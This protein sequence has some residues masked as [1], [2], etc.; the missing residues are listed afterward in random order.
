MVIS[1]WRPMKVTGCTPPGV[2]QRPRSRWWP[3]PRVRGGRD[4]EVSP[5]ESGRR[6]RHPDLASGERLQL[7]QDGHGPAGGVLLDDRSTTDARQRDAV[8]VDGERHRD[9]R[10]QIAVPMLGR[11]LLDEGERGRSRAAGSV[12]GR[13]VSEDC[14][15]AVLADLAHVSAKRLGLLDHPAQHAGRQRRRRVGARENAGAQK[16]DATVFPVNVGDRRRLRIIG[17]GR[18]HVGRRRGGR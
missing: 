9:L 8:D 15:D 11:D 6:L 5:Q 1:G 16:R 3:H 10:H 14:D 17:G 2:T 4:V 13:L 7:I 18:C 12:L